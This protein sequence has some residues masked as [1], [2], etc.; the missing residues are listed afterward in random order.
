M[1]GK[2]GALAGAF[3]IMQRGGW[4]RLGVVSRD[5]ECPEELTSPVSFS[6]AAGISKSGASP[7]AAVART[8]SAK[9]LSGPLPRSVEGCNGAV[10]RVAFRARG[11]SHNATSCAIWRAAEAMLEYGVNIV[12]VTDRGV[13]GRTRDRSSRRQ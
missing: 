12:A 7:L 8:L 2:R 10:V 11:G 4:R 3:V 6:V 1:T 9:P 13:P 5:M